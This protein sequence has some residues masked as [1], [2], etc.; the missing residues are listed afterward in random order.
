MGKPMR[1]KRNHNNRL[2]IKKGNRLKRR[3]K[4]F[5]QIYED[6]NDAQKNAA[7][8]NQEVDVDLPGLGQYYCIE[9]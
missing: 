1:K 6:V 7:L 8:S 4:D 2:T 9:C 3:T 5:D